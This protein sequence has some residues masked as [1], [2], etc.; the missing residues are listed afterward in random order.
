MKYTFQRASEGSKA[1]GREVRGGS[2]GRCREGPLKDAVEMVRIEMVDGGLLQDCLELGS[3]NLKDWILVRAHGTSVG[4]P[5]QD[6]MGNSEVA[7]LEGS[8]L[9]EF[10]RMTAKFGTTIVPS[11][12]VG[13]DDMAEL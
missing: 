5:T 1:M 4:L 12:A 11:G 8:M 7:S 2:D 13:E 3:S 10:V 6:D 9:K